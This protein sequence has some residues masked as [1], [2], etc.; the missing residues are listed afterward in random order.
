MTLYT[1]DADAIYAGIADHT[2]IADTVRIVSSKFPQ[3]LN[4][5][6]DFPNIEEITCSIICPLHK[7]DTL[8]TLI[9]SRHNLKT[10]GLTIYIP[11]PDSSNKSADT[12]PKRRRITELTPYLK[13]L[14]VT[15]PNI[16]RTLGMRMR[17]ITLNL[18]VIDIDSNDFTIIGLDKGL[19]YVTSNKTLH[20]GTAPIFHALEATGA[21]RG[22]MTDGHTR[23]NLNASECIPEVTVIAKL[24]QDG[25]PINPDY[26]ENLISKAEI[27]TII[28]D[29]DT[30][31]ARYEYSN[32][33]LGGSVGTLKQI[34]AI[35]PACEVTYHL[36]R[37]KNL[38]EIHVMVRNID[39]IEDMKY[40]MEKYSHRAISYCIHYVRNNDND[41]FWT[42]LKDFGDVV[43][44]DIVRTLM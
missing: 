32:I 16:I 26:V 2:I 13:A 44:K 17:Y 43:F 27:I 15:I 5:I 12:T 20:I 6:E 7:L 34:K 39:D 21:L 14:K 8:G 22:I 40:M 19:F 1:S 24:N 31:E 25:L 28:Y 42:C 41:N 10:L 18:T 11:Q 33:I 4:V 3:S 35:I 38:E 29:P 9:A 23:Y 37:N 30:I 36:R